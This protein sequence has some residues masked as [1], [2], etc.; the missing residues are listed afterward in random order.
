MII[1]IKYSKS[2]DLTY[3]IETR[4]PPFDRLSKSSQYFFISIHPFKRLFEK[5]LFV[6]LITLLAPLISPYKGGKLFP[7]FYKGRVKNI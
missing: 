7:P 3:L 1:G 4:I 2:I 6:I 5:W